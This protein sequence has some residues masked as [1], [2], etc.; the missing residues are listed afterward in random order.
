MKVLMISADFPPLIGGIATFSHNLAR[1]LQEA[2]CRV[3]VL[4]S[5]RPGRR[6]PVRDV[7]V[8]RTPA[9]LNRKGLKILPLLWVGAQIC[10][11]ERPDR[12]LAMTCAHEGIVAY[13]L[14][15]M[16]GVE[17]ALVAHGSEILQLPAT[18]LR[19]VVTNRI[20]RDAS[21]VVLNS[22]YTRGLVL[23]LGVDPFR[24]TVINPPLDLKGYPLDLDTAAVD[25][26]FRLTGKRVLLTASRLVKRKGHAQII[27]AIARLRER[28]PELVYVMTGDGDYRWELEELARRHGVADRVR[29]PGFVS[30]AELRQLYHRAEVYISPSQEDQ[31][32]I[33][34]FGIALIEAGA[35][36][37]PVIAG[38]SGGVTDAV[39]H[40]ETG[41]LVNPFDIE[42]ITRKLSLLLDD[43]AMRDQLGKAGRAQVVTKFGLMRQAEKLK[44]VLHTGDGRS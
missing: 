21:V 43:A 27:E 19:R 23:R 1:G 7:P 3:R 36:G 2:G 5:V 39:V 11:R 41:F 17:Y 38:R 35:Y 12:L 37:K 42:E 34:G 29:M 28:Y 14:K 13:V 40:G 32:D 31:G 4:T 25:E 26:R 20:F 10:R 24:V 6:E 8:V 9:V 30:Q 18:G 44:S 15:C 16:L 33:E 22:E